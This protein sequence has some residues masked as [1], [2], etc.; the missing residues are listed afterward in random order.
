MQDILKQ[1]QSLKEDFMNLIE[2]EGLGEPASD[3]P[4]STNKIKK[5][6]K[7]KNGKVE[8]VSVE[9]ELFPYDGNKREQYRQKIL[10]TINGMIQ[11]TATLEDL[12]QIVRQKKM[13]VKEELSE[14]SWKKIMEALEQLLG[15]SKAKDPKG[16]QENIDI[17]NHYDKLY[18]KEPAKAPDGSPN[19]VAAEW[20]RRYQHYFDKAMKCYY[21]DNKKEPLK[22]ALK[23][24]E[25]LFVNDG[26]GD[27][28]DDVSKALTTRTV[29]QNIKKVAQGLTKKIDRKKCSE[30]F[31]KNEEK[32]YNECRALQLWE[33]VINELE[34][35]TVNRAINNM[36]D[37]ID[38][39]KKI[40]AMSGSREF[41][42]AIEDAIAKKNHQ[43][44]VVQSKKEDKVVNRVKEDEA[45]KKKRK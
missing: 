29:G 24:L 21:G 11:G 45:K 37:K 12:L 35:G 30:N 31:D 7:T 3:V 8:L 19:S 23:I 43:I 26:R 2:V 20:K 5:D 22:E 9:D 1:I 4:P 27:L 34:D 36:R 15:E 40:Q 14:G 17:A 13:P 33:Q 6:K 38:L 39:A 44:N 18:S 25:G 10:D 16:Y 32:E 41:K 28:L 42:D